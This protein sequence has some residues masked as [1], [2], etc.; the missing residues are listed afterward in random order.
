MRETTLLKIVLICTIAGLA[1]LF[2]ISS[3]IEIPEY[4][5]EHSL[6]TEQ[7]VKLTGKIL[8]Y[9]DKGNVKFIELAHQSKMTV[10]LFENQ[11]VTLKA[12]D[13]IE[14]LGKLQKYDG[15]DEVIAQSI[16]GIR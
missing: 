8:Q 4:N 10:V 15:K 1:I 12:G 13:D 6:N 9:S 11:N 7:D 5:L 16:R 14:V 2:F 3:G